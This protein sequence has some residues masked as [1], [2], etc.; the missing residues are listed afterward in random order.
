ML[1]IYKDLIQTTIVL[2]THIKFDIKNQTKNRQ[3]HNRILNNMLRIPL[4][5][6]SQL[7][8]VPWKI[9]PNICELL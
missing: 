8:T 3:K 4:F 6:D 5:F 7:I 9:P 1:D 2:S